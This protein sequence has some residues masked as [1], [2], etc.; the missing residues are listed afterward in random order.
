MSLK[1]T[2]T[3]KIHHFKESKSILILLS[4]VI[5]TFCS[6]SILLEKLSITAR[7]QKKT[8]PTSRYFMSRN[9][10]PWEEMTLIWHFFFKEFLRDFVIMVKYDSYVTMNLALFYVLYS[11]TKAIIEGSQTLFVVRGYLLCLFLALHSDQA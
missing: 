8:W 3:F 2:K 5:A 6:D 7:L 9:H 4:F 1:W 10:F 11:I